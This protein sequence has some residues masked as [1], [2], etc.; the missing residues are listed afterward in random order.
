MAVVSTLLAAPLAIADAPQTGVVTGVVRGP[1]GAAMPGAT[2]QL[3]GDRGSQSAVADADGGFRFVFIVPGSYTV[4]AALTGF[5]SAEG[6]IVVSAGGRAFVELK[7]GEAMGEEIVVTGEV[8]LVSRY[9]VSASSTVES[10]VAEELVFN[11]RTYRSELLMFPGVVGWLDKGDRTVSAFGGSGNE[12]ASFI[13]GV[14]VSVTRSGGTTRLFLPTTAL[15]QV[16]VDGSG[17]GAEYGRVTGGVNAAIT[18]SGGN[19]FHGEAL[20]VAQNQAWAAQSKYVPLERPDDIQGKYEVSLGGPIVRNTLWFFAAVSETTTNEITHLASGEIVDDSL[21]TESQ[22]LKLDWSPGPSHRLAVTGL[23]APLEQATISEALFYDATNISLLKQDG[24]FVTAN[25]SWAIA[26]DMF[27]EL[28]GAVQRGPEDRGPISLPEVDPAEP[29]DDPLGNTSLYVDLRA[30]AGYHRGVGISSGG[31][32][33]PRDQAN[34][35]F[36]WFAG[37]HELEFG[38]DYQNADME[39]R[40]FREPVYYGQGYNEALPGG[41]AVPLFKRVYHPVDEPVRTESD[42]LN[43]FV[44]DRFDVGDRWTFAVGLRLEDQEHINDKGETVIY[45]SDLA[46]RL[47]AVYDVGGDGDLLIK[48]TAGRYYSLIYQNV[49]NTEFST[50]PTGSNSYDQYL[51]NRATGLY[52]RYQQ[53]VLPSGGDSLG[54]SELDPYHKDEITFGAEWQFDPLWVLKARAMYWESLDQWAAQDQFDDAAGVYRLVWNIPGVKREYTGLTLELNRRFRDGWVVRSNY[55]WSRLEGNAD[56]TFKEGYAAVDPETGVPITAINRWGRMENDRTHVLNVSGSRT[57]PVGKHSFQVGGFY[58]FI[59]G[60]PWNL[61]ENVTLDLDPADD[62][63]PTI[64]SRYFI[65]QQGARRLPDNHTLNL[66]AT[67]RFPIAGPVEGS[68]RVEAANVTDEQEQL[69]VNELSGEPTLVRSSW[70]KP[71][72]FR[73][74]VGVSF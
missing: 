7:L 45:S 67:W 56:G 9:D 46:P 43:T 6:G 32:N 48:A 57:F 61:Q 26:D 37:R 44:E 59:T 20:Y 8:P 28:R 51:F 33:F 22:L 1:D 10:E 17:Y 68:L 18:K 50:S 64:T 19:E 39:T 53:T 72:E 38:V 54:G 66:N 41:F 11:T 25:W 60:R 34:A 23:N 70:Q 16:R 62:T 30:P 31:L 74:V 40:Y 65:E 3:E 13:D 63:S 71:R 12:M 36:T 35:M 29:P 27:L 69:R 15:S 58:R 2:V 24:E 52:D 21:S 42:V 49:I 73:V 14:D 47:A 5:Q 55:T 4:R